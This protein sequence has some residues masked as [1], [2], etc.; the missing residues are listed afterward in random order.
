[1]RRK[2]G[3]IA[4]IIAGISFLLLIL[5]LLTGNAFSG[6]SFSPLT[7]I[8]MLGWFICAPTAAICLFK[9]IV[10]LIGK[11][12][13]AGQNQANPPFPIQPVVTNPPATPTQTET[14]AQGEGYTVYC[15]NCGKSIDASVT[16]CPHCG[17]KRL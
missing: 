4:A 14:P 10:T 2:I 9:D 16:F 13:S 17:F 1:M 15:T 7:I 12:F 5:V 3:I 11:W 8:G 6:H